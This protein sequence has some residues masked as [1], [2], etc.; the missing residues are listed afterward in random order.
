MV[1]ETGYTVVTDAISRLTY[2]VRPNESLVFVYTDK[3]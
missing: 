1:N 3:P 2:N